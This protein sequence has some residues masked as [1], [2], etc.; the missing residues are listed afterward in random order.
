[1][2]APDSDADDCADFTLMKIEDELAVAYYKKELYAFLIE[3][4]G[5]QILRPKIVG[6]LRGPV[7]RP[8]PGS[9]KLDAAKA[10]LR[11]LKEAD[12]VAGSFATGALFDLE[13]RAPDIAN[14]EIGKAN[15][16]TSEIDAGAQSR[17]SDSNVV[18]VCVCH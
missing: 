16:N 11:L 17:R 4:V 15:K 1:M 6:D 2:K 7:S 5:M 10:L 18:P 8:S 3:D 14:T 13:L 12:I 9:N